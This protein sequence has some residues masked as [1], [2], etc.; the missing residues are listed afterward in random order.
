MCTSTICLYMAGTCR[1]RNTRWH[2]QEE[3]GS[4]K[5]NQ[6]PDK[7]RNKVWNEFCPS[8][9]NRTSRGDVM[10]SW[11]GSIDKVHVVFFSKSRAIAELCSMGH[12]EHA[13]AVTTIPNRPQNRGSVN[14]APACRVKNPAAVTS[15][16]DDLP[17]P[18]KIANIKLWWWW[19]LGLG[20]RV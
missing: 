19:I 7:P 20:P 1:G 10:G 15:D 14:A 3:L 6:D 12:P 11:T 18:E 17:R 8:A 5:G 13:G 4:T 16:L 2:Q 9:N